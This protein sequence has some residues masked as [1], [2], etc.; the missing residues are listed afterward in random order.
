M[1]CSFY[2]TSIRDFKWLN[3]IANSEQCR[4]FIKIYSIA[5]ELYSVH[6]HTETHPH[7]HTFYIHFIDSRI[8]FRFRRIC[9]NISTLYHSSSVAHTFVRSSDWWNRGMRSKA[10]S[11]LHSCRSIFFFIGTHTHTRHF[12]MMEINEKVFTIGWYYE[13]LLSIHI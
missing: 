13:I 11:R 2:G 7:T 5:P 3:G 10:Y 4:K 6:T 12:S 9:G 8:L 1:R